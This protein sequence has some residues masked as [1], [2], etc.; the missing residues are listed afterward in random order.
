MVFEGIEPFE[1]K[2]PTGEPNFFKV[3]TSIGL[4]IEG[5]HGAHAIDALVQ[6]KDLEAILAVATPMVN[7]VFRALR[8]FGFLSHVDEIRPLAKDAEDTLRSWGAEFGEN[9]NDDWTK[10]APEKPRIWSALFGVAKGEQGLFRAERWP[11]IEEA[12]Q[13]NLEPG[14]ERE[15]LTNSLQHLRERNYRLALLE[16]VI[17]LEIVLNTYLRL[18]LS[19]YQNLSQT[20]IN[21]VVNSQLGLTTRVGLILELMLSNKE[22]DE[23]R[24]DEVVRAINWRNHIVHKTGRLPAELK[25]DGIIDGIWATLELAQALSSKRDDLASTPEANA[26]A[27]DIS[28]NFKVRVHEVKFLAGHRVTLSIHTGARTV[29]PPDDE[30]SAIVDEVIRRCRA[31]DARFA[32]DIHLSIKFLRGLMG[33]YAIWANGKLE[34][35]PEPSSVFGPP[36]LTPPS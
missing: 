1:T 9:E 24:I 22:R 27:A 6:A 3:L 11:L 29:S 31:R 17:C 35:L 28:K 34:R 36:S 15:F 7:R 13:D 4:Q 20:R 2:Q 32:P 26:F 23:S 12:I 25:E 8:N 10:L 16:A 30:L 21:K 5:G 19:T 33:T 14:P 18:Y